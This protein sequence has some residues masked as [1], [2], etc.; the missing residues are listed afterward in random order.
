MTTTFKQPHTLSTCL[1]TRS[2]STTGPAVLQLRHSHIMHDLVFSLQK[3][4]RASTNYVQHA[5]NIDRVVLFFHVRPSHQENGIR[6]FDNV[7][8]LFHVK[9]YEIGRVR[10]R[11]R[12]TRK[13]QKEDNTTTRA[14]EFGRI[15]KPT[16]ETLS[17]RL[18]ANAEEHDE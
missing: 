16:R 18:Y 6:L 10:Q 2:R 3:A 17:N 9:L 4:T 1:G 13:Q 8:E 14:V 11:I 15:A 7:P 12:L 5:L